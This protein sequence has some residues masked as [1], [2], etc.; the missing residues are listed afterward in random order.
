MSLPVA[1]TG[2]QSILRSLRAASS[3]GQDAATHGDAIDA[4]LDGSAAD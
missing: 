1:A 4:S 3:L 2:K